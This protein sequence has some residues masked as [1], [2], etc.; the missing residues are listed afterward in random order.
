MKKLNTKIII[1]SIMPSKAVSSPPPIPGPIYAV[2]RFG[3]RMIDIKAKSLII[4]KSY[5]KEL[6]F[7]K[8]TQLSYID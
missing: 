7:T 2:A 5:L 1:A 8:N 6:K 3:R 4:M